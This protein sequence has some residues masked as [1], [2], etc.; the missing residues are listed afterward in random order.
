MLLL[1]IGIVIPSASA[2]YIAPSIAHAGEGTRLSGANHGGSGHVFNSGHVLST[3]VSVS[4]AVVPGV[5]QTVEKSRGSA[6]ERYV[7]AK[8]CWSDPGGPDLILCAP[9]SSAY[10]IVFQ[11][12]SE[13]RHAQSPSSL[14]YPQDRPPRV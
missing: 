11:T 6:P 9:L 7:E 8:R 13:A 12:P 5:R 1:W 14:Q 10:P 4:A 3:G 2:Q